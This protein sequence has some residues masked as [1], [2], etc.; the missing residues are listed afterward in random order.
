M[1]QAV[2]WGSIEGLE[3]RHSEPVMDPFPVVVKDMKLDRDEGPRPEL[4][5]ADFGLS[6]EIARLMALLD[7]LNCGTIRL[8]EVREGIPRRMLVES[9]EYGTARHRYP[10]GP[11]E[12]RIS[13]RWHET[14][15]P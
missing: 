14:D 3:V 12:R 8:I 9:R 6:S 10:G 2:N 13:S 1:C 15:A 4:A 7:E 11:D 5:L